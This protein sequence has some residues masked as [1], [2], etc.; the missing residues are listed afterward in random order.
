MSAICRRLDGLPLAIELAAARVR[1]LTPRQIMERLADRFA[2]LGR[3]GGTAPERLRTLQACLRWS[4]D[5]CSKPEQMLWARLSVFSGAAQLDAMEG[6]CAD[7]EMPAEE[8]PALVAALVDKSIL[9]RIDDGQVTR[10]RMLDTVRDF[11]LEELRVDGQDAA[12]RRRH[13]DWYL[14]LVIRAQ[15]EWLS[16]RQAYWLARLGCEHANIRSAMEYCLVQPGEAET[17]LRIAV[18]LPPMHWI[19]KALFREGRHWLDRG[20]AQAPLPT[21]VRAQ[22]LL[23]ASQLAIGQGDPGA[24]A[25]LVDRGEALAVQLGAP[26]ELAYATYLRGLVVMF[27]AGDLSAAIGHFERALAA[28][29]AVSQRPS[30]LQIDLLL[31]LGHAVG[32]QGDRDRAAAL[33]HEVR[34]L[35]RP[36]DQGFYR[37]RM[38]WGRALAAW[39]HRDLDTAA[40]LVAKR[41]QPL[42]GQGP[43]DRYGIALSLEVLAWIAAADRQPLRA[44]TLL[45]AADSLWTDIGSSIGGYRY[46][47]DDHRQCERDARESLGDN[48]FRQAWELG[49]G[50]EPEQAVAFALGA[51]C[52]PDEVAAGAGSAGRSVA[53]TRRE[54]EVAELVMRGLTNR[55]IARRLFIS[56][57]TAESHLDH[58]LAKLGFSSREQVAAWMTGSHH[59]P[60]AER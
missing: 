55:G 10:Y 14:E 42:Q 13:R 6:I 25:E 60:H 2:V 27:A 34:R 21:P 29:Q 9:V 49:R 50:L 57:R 18:S 12:V 26:A 47:E 7:D 3:G 51:E 46:L 5:L 44:A 11:G 31:T 48:A 22:A 30:Q 39:R 19:A 8:M 58:I 43:D 56:Q 52:A 33:E 16:E 37:A 54:R 20:L 23:L 1:V 17:A 40:A 35:T 4:F 41:L 24:G 28:L 59:T 36:W 15:Q 45:G 32:L 38:V 53:L